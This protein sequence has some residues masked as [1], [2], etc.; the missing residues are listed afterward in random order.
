MP[1]IGLNGQVKIVQRDPRQH[2]RIEYKRELGCF[3]RVCVHTGGDE[4]CGNRGSSL[5]G[6]IQFSPDFRSGNQL[7]M[8]PAWTNAILFEVERDVGRGT[9]L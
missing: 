1:K 6:G 4:S 9:R 3:G 8:C 7:M 2:E 5:K